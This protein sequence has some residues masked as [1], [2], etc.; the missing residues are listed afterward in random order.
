MNLLELMVKIG[1]E[2][3]TTS[4]ISGISKKIKSGLGTAAKVGAAAMAVTGA[5]VAGASKAFVEGVNNVAEYGDQIDKMSQK[6]GLSAEAYQEWD[7]VMQHSGT[8]MEAMKASMKTLANAAET[9]NKAFE[10]IGLTQEQIATMDQQQLFEATI[11]GLQNVEN[12]TERTYLA[13]KLL[14]RG[15]TELGSLLNQSAEDTQKMR[16]RV[17][18]LG[19]VMSDESVKA[20]AAFKDNLQDLQTAVSGLQR[21]LLGEFMPSLSTI[22]EGLQDVFSGD[23]E[24][25]LDKI[26]QGVEEGIAKLSEVV[27]VA[28]ERGSQIVGAIVSGIVANAP[29]IL[30]GLKNAVIE[31][32]NSLGSN[33]GSVA[34]GAIQ[35]FQGLLQGIAEIAPQVL[36]AVISLLGSLVTEIVN[37][38]PEILSAAGELMLGLVEGIANGIAPAMSA[39]NSG[40]QSLLNA[41]GSIACSMASSAW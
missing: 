24:V 4:K 6:M 3:E 27:P 5:A 7:A 19:G 9:G 38:A 16:D 21:N 17:H 20:A 28:M 13:G 31:A 39:L 29:K 14:G 34:E 12:T 32:A 35:A 15:A 41:V 22:M 8:S 23:Y 40:V 25:G 11:A 37:H 18:E 2:D 1:I 26:S 30:D 10:K 36:E 33:S